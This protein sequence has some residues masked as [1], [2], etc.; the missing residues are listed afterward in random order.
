MDCS[1]PGSFV[2]GIYQARIQ[3][4]VA[5]SFSKDLPNPE[6]ESTSPPLAGEFFTTEPPG[7]IMVKAN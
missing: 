2:H 7:M 3:E 5:I 6:I 4:W 1:L